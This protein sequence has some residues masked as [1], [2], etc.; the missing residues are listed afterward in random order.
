MPRIASWRKWRGFTLIELLVVI[1]IIAILIGLLLPAVQKVREA[2]ARTQSANNLKQCSLALHNCNDT[3]GK[4][5][6]AEGMFPQRGPI[7]TN[8]PNWQ[9]PSPIGTIFYFLGPFVEQD[10]MYKSTQYTSW[11]N[12]SL[13]N[14]ANGQIKTFAA[15][16][17]PSAPSNGIEP[18]FG[19][20]GVASYSANFLV[21][22]TGVRYGFGNY[23]NGQ[24][25]ADGGYARI[26]ATFID[27]T[28]N[29]IV[30]MER[31]HVCTNNGSYYLNWAN[32]GSYTQ[33]Q[34]YAPYWP[35]WNNTGGIANVGP[36]QLPPNPSFPT[37]GQSPNANFPVPQAKP[38]L[39]NSAPIQNQCQS[40]LT[41]GFST[42]GCMV[43][44][45]D[46]SV[47]M[48]NSSISAN[49]W[50]YALWPNDGQVLGSDW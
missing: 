36:G 25:G 4:L 17:D 34:Q 7:N 46:G 21:F 23:L 30:F 35:N 47:R 26:P 49:T 1:A 3:Y 45:G 2:A 11:Y 48:V 31:Y 42:A 12:P 14:S 5:P 33:N 19:N 41:Q 28:S 44:L 29:T 15:P 43:G 9:V 37:G 40:N 50:S 8:Q 6:P 18:N 22:G 10:N 38:S 13:P 27:G 39:S 24:T 20:M 32:D 16:G